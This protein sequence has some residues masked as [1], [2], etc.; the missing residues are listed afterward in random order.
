MAMAM[1]R[2]ATMAM[3]TGG[4]I[5]PIRAPML[6]RVR[7][8]TFMVIGES[9]PADE[10]AKTA[11][12]VAGAAVGVAGT[13]ASAVDNAIPVVSGA[14]DTAVPVVKGAAQL[15]L[16]AASLG[17][18]VAHKTVD[19]AGPVV[20][21][22]SKVLMPAIAGGF[23]TL[24]YAMDHNGD[25]AIQL[26]PI[27]VAEVVSSPFA[28]A[29][30]DA[31]PWLVGLIVFYLAAKAV[32]KKTQDALASIMPPTMA[33]LGLGTALTVAVKT[34]VI[35]IDPT[36][37]ALAAVAGLILLIPG[38]R[39]AEEDTATYK[40]TSDSNNI[41]PKTSAVPKAAKNVVKSRVK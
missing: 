24:S 22:G 16:G 41:V 12:D 31:S 13:V 28:L 34:E 11:A 21:E 14:V 38:N 23:R 10:I 2:V 26:A 29:L 7:S 17:L 18:E 19:V 35:V 32:L 4:M 6:A 1:V 25:M 9:L 5:G 37:F 20:V 15:G 8:T 33:V 39:Q 27:D 36:P 30:A 3:A 40:T